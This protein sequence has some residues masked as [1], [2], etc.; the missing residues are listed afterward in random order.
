[1][2]RIWRAL[3]AL[4]SILFS[5][6]AS[7]VDYASVAPGVSYAHVVNPTVPWSMHITKFDYSRHDLHLITTH[8]KGT[9]FGLAT[10]KD[11]VAAIPKSAGRPIAAVN[12]D[13]FLI[14]KKPYQG[15]PR[16]LQ[17]LDGELVS[18]PSRDI[19]FWVDALGEPHMDTVTP[20]FKLKLPHGKPIDFGL[21]ETRLDNA[22]TLLTPT[23]G[24]STRT[25]NGLEVVLRPEGSGPWLPVRAGD[26]YPARITEIN[27][28]GN[29]TLHPGELVV[30]IGPKLI[31]RLPA[32]SNGE[33]VDVSLSLSPPLKGIQTAIGGRPALVRNGK[34]LHRQPSVKTDHMNQRNPRTAIG[35]NNHEFFMVVVDGRKPGLSV[36][37]TLP[38]LASLMIDLGCKDAMNLDGGGSTTMWL[39]GKV[40][41]HPSEKAERRV[42]NCL[43]L[44]ANP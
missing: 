9:V 40:V 11:Q 41:N 44:V 20:K 25:S 5:A 42:A 16:G 31:P 8:A 27:T 12:G 23:L 6:N 28:N 1:M 14:E 19:V 29:T 4:L 13:F 15:D 17:I 43:V 36:G 37:M 21:N 24:R 7:T 3:I 32:L 38:E 22:V 2:S 18:G 34:N 39:K 30:S 26:K 10:V 33:H 35:W